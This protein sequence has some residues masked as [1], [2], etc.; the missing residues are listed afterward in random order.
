M[1]RH[2]RPPVTP[3]QQTVSTWVL[4]GCGTALT[5]TSTFSKGSAGAGI[6][7]GREKVAHPDP[8]R[9]LQRRGNQASVAPLRFRL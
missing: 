4:D 1:R 3:A 6:G 5:R 9:C 2:N 8:V 7:Q